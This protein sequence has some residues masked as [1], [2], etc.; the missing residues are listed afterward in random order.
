MLTNNQRH[1]NGGDNLILRKFKT[2]KLK[3]STFMS[4][5]GQLPTFAGKPDYHGP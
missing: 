3:T 4:I 1:F 2:I 5:V